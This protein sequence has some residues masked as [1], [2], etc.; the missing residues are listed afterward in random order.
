MHSLH[1]CAPHGRVTEWAVP[2]FVLLSFCAWPEQYYS[3]KKQYCLDQQ[4]DF[5]AACAKDLKSKT[6]FLPE[7]GG[8]NY[9]R[10]LHMKAEMEDSEDNAWIQLWNSAWKQSDILKLTQEGKVAIKRPEMIPQV[11]VLC[12]CPAVCL[13]VA[14]IPAQ[15]R[16]PSKYSCLTVWRFCLSFARRNFMFECDF[17]AVMLEEK[18]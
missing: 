11:L 16:K 1:V 3:K 5:V 17:A 18:A 14:F 10:L 12:Q 4:L 7:I 8:G 2:S 6:I 13:P 9:A 15:Q